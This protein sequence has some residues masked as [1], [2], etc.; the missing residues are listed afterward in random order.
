M[1]SHRK[2]VLFVCTHNSARS[3][4]AEII[5]RQKYGN[6]FNVFS[7]GTN[8]T[9]I[10]PFVN[11]IL[12]EMGINTSNLKSKNVKEFLDQKID[13]VVT[14]CDSAKETCPVFPGA[15]QYTHKS[16]KDPNEFSGTSEEIFHAVRGIR[17]EI[18]MW[19]EKKF[20]PRS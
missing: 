10:N 18:A 5:L 15:K 6:H 16:F 13:L 4:L 1:V 3:Q 12:T 8:P 11:L 20:A 14:V 19:I 2:T 17:D 9:S 7:A